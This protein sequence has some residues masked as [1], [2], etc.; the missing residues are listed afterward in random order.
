MK[1]ERACRRER[2]GHGFGARSVG[3]ACP[4]AGLAPSAALLPSAA[5][6][7]FP[8]LPPS[9][10]LLAQAASEYVSISQ[11]VRGVRSFFAS[12]PGLVADNPLESAVA[13]VAVL[14]FAWMVARIT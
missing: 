14:L 5:L 9:P 12:L 13:V 2:Q 7:T 11:I 6:P 1:K 8:A 10:A 4:A 3:Q